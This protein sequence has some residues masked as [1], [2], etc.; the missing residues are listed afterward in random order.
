MSRIVAVVAI[1]FVLAAC[2]KAD[3]N[4]PKYWEKLL[5]NPKK[6]ADAL[7]RIGDELMEPGQKEWGAKL[8]VKYFDRGPEKAATAL[9]KLGQGG[10]DV[11][12]KL[13]EGLRSNDPLL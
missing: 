4:T 3:P 8:V 11:V 1:A 9:G 10:D 13:I 7:G 12:D 6:A 2:S 5:E